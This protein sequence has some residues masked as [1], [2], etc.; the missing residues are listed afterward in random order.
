MDEV[1]PLHPAS[2]GFT[3]LLGLLV[4]VVPRRYAIVPIVVGGI[5][6]PA[7][8]RIVILTLDWQMFRLLILFAF[9]RLLVRGEF[10]P[11]K[12]LPMDYC[13]FALAIWTIV[14]RTLLFG[15]V[16]VTVNALGRTFESIG[17]YVCARMFFRTWRDLT[18]T[19]QVVLGCTLVLAGFMS[20]EAATGRNLFAAIGGVPFETVIRE[21][22]L[23]CQGAFAHPIMAG[24][25]GATWFPLFVAFWWLGQRPL[26][27]IGGVSATVVTFAS[28]SSTPVMALILSIIALLAW[29]IRG[30]LRQIR[31]ATFGLGVVLHFVREKP[32]W[33]LISRLNVVGGSTG[34]HR[35]NVMD[36]AIR[37]WN[38]WVVL[39]AKSIDHWGIWANDVTN[40][41]VVVGIGGGLVAMCLFIAILAYGFQGAGAA[42]KARVLNPAQRRFAWC[43]GAM[44]FSH[45]VSFTSVSYF[46]QMRTVFYLQLG[47]VASLADIHRRAK[48]KVARER[49]S[50]RVASFRTQSAE[51]VSRAG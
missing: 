27:V 15:Q 48:R 19:I 18:A 16:G 6:I 3:L 29:P 22:R 38:E 14:A 12:L 33:H 51:A 45:A 46:G 36:Q 1:K 26:A 5:F 10:A 17:I 9:T 24:V 35:Y 42:A 41:Y 31:W 13:V 32:I 47:I 11:F 50:V 44:L 30:N 43:I 2:L 39:G 21:G 4:L 40:E 23:R 34:W 28:A 7:D 20:L 25:F 37:H 49:R 8:Q